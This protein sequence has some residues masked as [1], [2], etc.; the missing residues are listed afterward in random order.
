VKKISAWI[1]S[2]TLAAA[3]LCAGSDGETVADLDTRYQR[4]VKA[5][6]AETMDAIL[7]DDFILV[8]GTG[9]V[10]DKRQLLAVTRQRTIAYERQDE[11]PG[12]RTVRVYGDTAVVTAR[13][14]LKDGS[15]GRSVD[16]KLWFS[17]TYVRTP[18]GWRYAFGQASLPL[19]ANG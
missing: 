5:N 7:H 15:D 2:L 9:A 16:I 1:L 13:L 19:P 17:D 8:L 11:E 3:P 10:F 18:Q 6:D 12:S 4:A 14:W